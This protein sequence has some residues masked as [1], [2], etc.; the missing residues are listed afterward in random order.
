MAFRIYIGTEFTKT[1]A[2]ISPS[3]L[4]VATKD[5]LLRASQ[6]FGGVTIT[7]GQGAWVNPA[8][9]LVEEACIILDIG[10]EDTAKVD[11]FAAF[12]RDT[13]SQQSVAV[14]NLSPLPM[15]FV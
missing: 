1:G 5:I 13:L 3:F 15:Q 8:G 6:E 9:E 10:T 14:Q 12:C 4:P 7:R 2:R 11:Q